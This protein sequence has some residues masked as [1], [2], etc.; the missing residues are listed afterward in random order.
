MMMTMKQLF[1][2]SLLE[3]NPGGQPGNKNAAGPH[4]RNTIDIS[5]PTMYKSGISR[6]ASVWVTCGKLVAGDFDEKQGSQRYYK[7][8]SVKRALQLMDVAKKNKW[9]QVK[10]NSAV[11]ARFVR[12]K[13]SP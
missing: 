11:G 12:T 1:G 6:D 3:R 2:I 10:G 4:R 8:V 7:N 9:K 5:M 13:D